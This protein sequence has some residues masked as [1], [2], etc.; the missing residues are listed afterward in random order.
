MKLKKVMRVSGRPFLEEAF[1]KIEDLAFSNQR[2]EEENLK[3]VDTLQYFG[4]S[5]RK[6]YLNDM[7]KIAETVN[8]KKQQELKVKSLAQFIM[9]MAH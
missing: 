2:E 4:E 7:V 5:M 1:D 6:I 8:S 3:V 9:K